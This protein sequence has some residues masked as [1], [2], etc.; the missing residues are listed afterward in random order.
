M[1]N[2]HVFRGFSE[3]HKNFYANIGQALNDNVVLSVLNVSHCENFPVKNFIGQNPESLAQ[4]IFPRLLYKV[5]I[6]IKT[7]YI[8]M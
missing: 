5:N 7:M 6:I 1:L 8:H 3:Y 4:R 2:F